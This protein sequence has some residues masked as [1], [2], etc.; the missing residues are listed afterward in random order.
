MLKKISFS[1]T[2]V[3]TTLLA[4]VAVFNTVTMV[5]RAR[6]GDSCPTLFGFATAVVIS[7]SMEPTIRVNDLVV[8]RA[9]KEYNVDDVVTFRGDGLP[10]THRIIGERTDGAGVRYFITQGDNNNTPDRSE[11]TADKIAGK[12]IRTVP[13]FGYV[14]SFLQKPI[15]FVVLSVALIAALFLPEATCRLATLIKRLRRSDHTEN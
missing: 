8:I 12:V 5:K 6:T 4:L 7:G 2:F 14:Q 13:K 15:G 9:Q 3:L 11:I 1:I 10:V